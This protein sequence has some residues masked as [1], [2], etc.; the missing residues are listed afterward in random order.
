M[1]L[2]LLLNSILI[3]IQKKFKLPILLRLLHVV[4]GSRLDIDALSLS[5]LR[6]SMSIEALFVRGSN[7]FEI[8]DLLNIFKLNIIF[9]LILI[10]L[11]KNNSLIENTQIMNTANMINWVLA[12]AVLCEAMKPYILH[13]CRTLFAQWMLINRLDAHKT[14]ESHIPLKLLRA[15]SGSWRVLIC[16]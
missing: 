9:S 3:F 16:C 6:L 1:H 2:K 4:L 15:L 11:N 12:W 13:I 14:K 7:V 10:E 5:I 8:V